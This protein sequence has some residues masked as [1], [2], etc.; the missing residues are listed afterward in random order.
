MNV[1]HNV[2]TCE[3]CQIVQTRELMSMHYV[4]AAMTH[5]YIYNY[6]HVMMWKCNIPGGKIFQV[7]VREI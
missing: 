1:P 5:T 6:I 3:P 7:T 2:V 4:L